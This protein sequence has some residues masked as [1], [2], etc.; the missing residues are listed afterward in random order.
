MQFSGEIILCIL[1]SIMYLDQH[2]SFITTNQI[3]YILVAYEFEYEKSISKDEGSILLPDNSLNSR[4]LS[5][6]DN[7]LGSCVSLFGFSLCLTGQ[8]CGNGKDV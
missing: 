4:L 6:H 8:I 3:R 5:V 7:R 2:L 1:T